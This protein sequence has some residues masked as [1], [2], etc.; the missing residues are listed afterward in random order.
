MALVSQNEFNFT[1]SLLLAEERL[2][3]PGMPQTK[4]KAFAWHGLYPVTPFYVRWPRVGP[5]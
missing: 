2:K 3:R 5:K 4:D 1:R